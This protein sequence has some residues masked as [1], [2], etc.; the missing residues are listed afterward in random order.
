MSNPI[1]EKWYKRIAD[2]IIFESQPA[3]QKILDENWPGWKVKV[4]D[5]NVGIVYDEQGEERFRIVPT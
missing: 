5:D 1:I 3:A 2:A 4:S